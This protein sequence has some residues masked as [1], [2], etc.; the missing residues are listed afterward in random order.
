LIRA[1]GA[2]PRAVLIA[3]DRMER[4]GKDGALSEHSAVQEVTR[5]YNMPVVSIGN[6]NDLL[7]Y[8]SQAGAGA[9]LA[10]Y[11]EAV[12]AYRSRYGIG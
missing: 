2:T 4:S 1:A 7:E 9:E 11:K 8:I 5:T 3:L 6:L 10:Q 12:A